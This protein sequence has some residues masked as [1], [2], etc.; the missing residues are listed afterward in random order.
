M[1]TRIYVGNLSCDTS[2]AVLADR[3]A[4]HGSVERCMIIADNF[5][6]RSRG[7]GF[8]EVATGDADKVIAALD[9]SDIDGRTIVVDEARPRK[10]CSYVGGPR[11]A[12]VPAGAVHQSSY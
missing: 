4:Q 7:F 2:E 5:S 6:G 11:R 1:G 8:V 9:A 12:P 3:F 10:V